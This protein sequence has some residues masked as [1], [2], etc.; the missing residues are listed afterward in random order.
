MKTKLV[1]ILTVAAM[2]TL[3]GNAF[4]G[5]KKTVTNN[6]HQVTA[7]VNKVVAVQAPAQATEKK[8]IWNNRGQ[9]IAVIPAA[10]R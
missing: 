5:E 3:G 7:V 4:A 6:R 9:L 1:L 8:L 10:S 2:S